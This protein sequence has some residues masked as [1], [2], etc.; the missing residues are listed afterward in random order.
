MPTALR[1]YI[2]ASVLFV[3]VI[4]LAVVIPSAARLPMLLGVMGSLS[5][6]FFKATRQP[7]VK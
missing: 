5:V 6:A 7:N 3:L 2:L 1:P 4:M